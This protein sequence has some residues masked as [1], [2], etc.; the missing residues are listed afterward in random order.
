MLSSSSKTYN[1][2]VENI[3]DIDLTDFEFSDKTNQFIVSLMVSHLK[4]SGYDNI[5]VRY[6]V[7]EGVKCYF[8]VFNSSAKVFNTTYTLNG[9]INIMPHIWSSRITMTDCDGNEFAFKSG[10]ASR[11]TLSHYFSTNRIK[12]FKKRSKYITKY[13]TFNLIDDMINTVKQ[14]TLTNIWN[15]IRE[16]L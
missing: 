2:F 10:Y 8:I 1:K 13:C 5:N 9:K 7:D 16:E 15:T 6:V 4:K 12:D 14:N 11:S 3:K